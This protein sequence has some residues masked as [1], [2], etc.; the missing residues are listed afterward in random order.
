[1]DTTAYKNPNQNYFSS[2]ATFDTSK[3]I[4]V[5]SLTTSEKPII[6]PEVP[7]LP[8]AENLANFSIADLTATPAPTATANQKTATMD[9]LKGL[10]EKTFGKSADQQ[11]MEAQAGIP[12]RTAELTKAINDFR[13]T[14]AEQNQLIQEQ[15]AIPL[16]LQEQVQGRGVTAGGLAPIQA[17]EL[18]KNAI[19]QYQ[20]TSK[21]LFQQAIVANLREDIAGAQANIEKAISYKYAPIEQEIAYLKDVVLPDLKDSLSK[22]DKKREQD[23]QIRL[24]ERTRLLNNAKEDS[25][26]GANLALTAMNNFPNDKQAQLNAQLAMQEAQKEQPDLNKIFQLVGQY[27]KDPVATAQQLENLRKTRQENAKLQLEADK[28]KAE[29]NASNIDTSKLN[30][31]GKAILASVNNLRF[32]SV[33]ESNRIRKNIANRLAQGDV[34]GAINDLKQF[35]YQKLG[36]SDKSDYKAYSGAISSFDSASKQIDAQNLV[37]GPYKALA[38]KT[39]PWVSIK[40]DKAYTDLRGTIELGQAQ[41]RKGFYGTAVTD[42]EAGNAKNFLVSDS[43]SLPVIKWKLDNAKNFL[44]FT[45]DSTVAQA[46]GLPKPNLDDYLKYRVREKATGRIGTVNRS[47]YDSGQYELLNQ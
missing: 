31:Q 40:N 16:A 25:T 17:G 23:L 22:E 8:N 20:V 30:S 18:R 41:L 32:S 38:E 43:D 26:A 46:V 14:T 39:K 2:G 24:N 33:E 10:Y 7:T 19:K 15:G 34:E 1:M 11:A 9:Y 37:A 21:G 44:Q 42:S 6:T 4:P 12:Q 45:N 29:T 47:E 27:Q 13:T 28:I 5:S 36:E 35:G 3:S